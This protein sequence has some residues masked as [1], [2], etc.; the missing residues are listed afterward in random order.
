MWCSNI[1]G[2][3][4]QGKQRELSDH[5]K[6]KNWKKKKTWDDEINT[7]RSTGLQVSAKILNPTKSD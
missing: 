1:A 7:K 2:R 3:E 4:N 6:L 5:W